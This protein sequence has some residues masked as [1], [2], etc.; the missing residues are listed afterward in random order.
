MM[1]RDE[2]MPN[3]V[4]EPD[5]PSDERERAIAAANEVMKSVG[6]V[7]AGRRDFT[8]GFVPE[9]TIAMAR[10]VLRYVPAG[11]PAST[12][13]A[14]ATADD[15]TRP[16]VMRP[17]SVTPDGH[18]PAA[19]PYTGSP[20]IDFPASGVI[21]EPITEDSSGVCE[22]SDDASTSQNKLNFTAAYDINVHGDHTKR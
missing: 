1:G 12:P 6:M 9:D 3:V 21:C 19:A 18:K 17:S 20:A 14:V 4:R 15:R 16:A 8:Y 13:H 7:V 22:A 5:M 11:V 10:A 2:S